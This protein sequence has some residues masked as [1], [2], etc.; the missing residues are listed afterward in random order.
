MARSTRT[1]IEPAEAILAALVGVGVG[2]SA[3]LIWHGRQ[4]LSGIAGRHPIVLTYLAAHLA[5]ILP[6]WA[7]PLA[8][9]GRGVRHVAARA[10]R[11]VADAIEG[12][13]LE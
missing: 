6:Q 9:A 3:V 13:P 4:P 8:W 11:A 12:G 10:T 5:G 7:D 1:T 2:S